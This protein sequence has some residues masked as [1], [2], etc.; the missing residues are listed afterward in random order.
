M[1]EEQSP[2]LEAEK[3]T[4]L[5]EIKKACANKDVNALARHTATPFGLVSDELRRIACE[6]AEE[7]FLRPL[8]IYCQG[9]CY[10]IARR[11][12]SPTLIGS[13]DHHIVM[14]RKSSWT[15]IDPLYIIQI[16]SRLLLHHRNILIWQ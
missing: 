1:V 5:D 8:L 2:A 10:L 4:K 9:L 12:Q 14:R 7:L 13:H 16:V 15:W 11:S 3:R 6:N